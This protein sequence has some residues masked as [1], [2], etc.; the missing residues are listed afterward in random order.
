[1]KMR[2][3]A[4]VLLVTASMAWVQP[5]AQA[6]TTA[7]PS[8]ARS[9]R[10]A[11]VQMPSVDHD[12]DANLRRATGFAEQAVAQRAQFILFPELMATGSYLAAD[13]WDSAEPANG[14][15]VQWLKATSRRLHMWIATTFLEASGTDFYD[16][17]V[18][19]APTGDEAGRVRKQ[20]PAGPEAYFFRGETGSHVI[21]TSIGKI[22]VGIC[23]ENY[24]CFA[25]SQF[26]HDSVDFVV[27]PHATPDMSKS[28]GLPTPPGTHLALWYARM[29]GVPVAMVN[30]VGPSYKP[31]PYEI[32]GVFRG[33][34]AIVDS[35]ATV[36]QSMDDKEGIGVATITLDAGR[37]TH[38]PQVCTGIGI[39][40]LAVGGAQGAK[41]VA[42]EY[43]RAR[44]SYENNLVRKVKARAISGSQPQ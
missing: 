32:N 15:S 6:P 13:S 17:F 30:K 16:T 4:V 24:Y 23:A 14:K 40:E 28:G 29:L 5:R 34:S 33:E 37:K 8:G 20:I 2:R 27:M 43:E 36:L 1:M 39:A 38:A 22:G 21:A 26:L 42:D 3:F 41:S 18:L 25:A 44:Q 35:D 9:L 31:P 19:T 10:L 11:V 7:A 12:V